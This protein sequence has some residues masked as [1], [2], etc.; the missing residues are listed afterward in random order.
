[1][2][3]FERA[4]PDLGESRFGRF[5]AEFPRH[6]AGPGRTPARCGVTIRADLL[7][8]DYR[9]RPGSQIDPLH[10][11][12]PADEDRLQKQLARLCPSSG[13]PRQGR[14][15]ES[16]PFSSFGMTHEIRDAQKG[17]VDGVTADPRTIPVSV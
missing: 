11:S 13:G 17:R 4:S 14:N 8:Q 2:A 5:C 3:S 6:S 15:R 10:A 1:M 9:D 7:L 12:I 16:P